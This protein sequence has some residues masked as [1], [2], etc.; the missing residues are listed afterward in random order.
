M[1]RIASGRGN[2]PC[3]KAILRVIEINEH[4]GIDEREVSFTFTRSPKPGGQNVN[5]LATKALL[6]FDVDASPS[7][8]NDQKRLLHRRLATR[9]SSDGVL[10]IACW[11]FRTQVA[12]RR[13]AIERFRTLVADALKPRKKRRPTRPSRAAVER[14]LSEKRR[15]SDLK[16]QRGRSVR[17]DD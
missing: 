14:R 7:L 11:R 4:L 2:S 1:L 8:S 12:N 13:E 9:I 5:K 6:R 10:Q 15:R 3:N 17:N 16:R